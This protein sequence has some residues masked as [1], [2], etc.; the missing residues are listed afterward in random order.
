[1]KILRSYIAL[2]AWLISSQLFG[3]DGIYYLRVGNEFSIKFTDQTLER[4]TDQIF[5]VKENDTTFT[6]NERLDYTEIAQTI[7]LK[8]KVN[9]DSVAVF[10]GYENRYGVS[11]SETEGA[12]IYNGKENEASHFSGWKKAKVLDANRKYSLS[13]FGFG[14]G[15][16]NDAPP[17]MEKDEV[18]KWCEELDW[19]PEGHVAVYCSRMIVKVTIFY[20]GNAQSYYLNFDRR[21]GEC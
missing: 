5:F 9:F 6:F 13:F 16:V 15:F 7:K 20:E 18:R 11:I 12:L 21:V 3:Q 14:K 2:V 19:C 17:E 8:L 4:C 10:A 1:M